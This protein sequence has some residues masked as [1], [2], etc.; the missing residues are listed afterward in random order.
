MKVSYFEILAPETMICQTSTKSTVFF[1]LL[2]IGFSSPI[3]HGLCSFGFGARHILRQYA[4]NDV[5]K[6][7]AIKTRFSKPVYP[8]QT[9]Q[10]DMW[11]E[12]NRIFFQCK[13]VESGHLVLSGGYVDLK[14]MDDA[15][16]T[17]PVSSCQQQFRWF[18]FFLVRK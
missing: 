12:G 18:C 15:K 16:T 7:K 2:Q 10:T 11:R 13:V 14:D 3:L 6:F 4:N 8:G 5:T 9:I 1:A 17:M